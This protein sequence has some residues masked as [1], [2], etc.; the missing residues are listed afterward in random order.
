MSG[1]LF[2]AGRVSDFDFVPEI[3][4]RN[5]VRNK[6]TRGRSAPIW[7]RISRPVPA[8]GVPWCTHFPVP[9]FSDAQCRNFPGFPVKIAAYC[10]LAFFW[11]ADILCSVLC[12]E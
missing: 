5:K 11:N 6:T 8:P 12:L 7:R 9:V 3:P 10:I 1:T 4:V 2:P